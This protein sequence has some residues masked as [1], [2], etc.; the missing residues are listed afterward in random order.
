MRPLP[1]ATRSA[2]DRG[3]VGLRLA[4]IRLGALGDI[5]R[6][7]PAVRLVRAALP[8]AEIHWICDDRW[9]SVLRGH[10]DLDGVTTFPRRPTS[11]GRSKPIGRLVALRSFRADL[12]RL[13]PGIALDFQ[14]NLRSGVVGRLTG[15]RIR[16]GHGGHQQ[17]EAN[18]VFTTHRVPAGERRRSRIERALDL[19]RALGIP[20]GPLPDGGL[21]RDR[22]ADRRAAALIADL[23][24]GAREVAVINPGAS[25]RQA[26]KKPPPAL[27][28]AAARLLEARDVAPIVVHGP[29]E[30]EDARRVVALAGDAALPAPPT[31]LPLLFAIL[32]EARLF[33][34]GDTGPLHAACALGCPVV[35]LYGPTDPVVN[36]PWGV[37]YRSV[38]P[39]GR[40]Y[41]GIKRRDRAGG[42]FDGLE[43]AAVAEAVDAMLATTQDSRSSSRSSI[44]DAS[45]A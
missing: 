44:S 9:S 42:G 26:Y 15:A 1:G 27:L 20:D 21:P 18:F 16:L 2:I 43:E 31:D 41:T 22:E 11:L 24:R 13:A 14:G 32:R 30:E 3:G 39:A 29:G 28:A 25:R 12:A 19:V 23:A 36:S 34:G 45:D 8:R 4:V 35:A 37:P 17:R 33:V 5:L 6:T 40:T 7:L 10:P 38:A